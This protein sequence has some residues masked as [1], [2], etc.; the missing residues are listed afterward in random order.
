MTATRSFLA[1]QVVLNSVQCTKFSTGVLGAMIILVLFEGL[2]PV[3]TTNST[4]NST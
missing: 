2:F 1:Q 4:S 3:D